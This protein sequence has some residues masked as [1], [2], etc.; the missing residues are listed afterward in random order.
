MTLA[1]FYI[2]IDLGF[3][4]KVADFGLSESLDITKDY[5]RQLKDNYMKLPVK[6]LALE[7]INDG[8]F[9]EKTDVVHEFED[10]YFVA[11]INTFILIVG[12]WSDM[13]G[14][15]QWWQGPLPRTSSPGD[16]SEAGKWVPHGEA[17]Q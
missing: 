16:C 2:R 15:V 10:H 12:I 8:I 7:C 5:Y 13:L 11:K 1:I 4:I 14:G 3:V 9:T 17:I 6:W